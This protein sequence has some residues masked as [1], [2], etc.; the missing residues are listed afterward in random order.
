MNYE[1]VS[2][3]SLAGMIFTLIMCFV[4]A[5]ALM[6]VLYK[7]MK[8]KAGSFF[9]AWLVYLIFVIGL[10]Q[11][12][13]KLI[14]NVGLAEA[15]TSNY[16]I[17][18]LYSGLTAAIFEEG[19][20]F[21]AIRFTMK[22]NLNKYNALMFGLGWAA[23]EGIMVTGLTYMNNL[24]VSL[25]LNNGQIEELLTG[26]TDEEIAATLE[27]ISGLWTMAPYEFFMGGVERIFALIVQVSVTVLIYKA[28]KER[29]ALYFVT[30]FMIHMMIGYLT[31]WLGTS[32]PIFAA[33]LIVLILSLLIGKYALKVYE[34]DI[35]D[36]I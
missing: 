28:V 29:S 1:T 25:M 26:L 17:Y 30:A 15:I 23:I 18:A 4:P 22:N 35:C 34:E 7:K 27:G 13:H 33:D 5:F 16:L 31:V 2:A 6:Y 9:I 21:L 32:L 36:I 14:L 11:L 19:G 12:F 3:A 20:R 10:E 8:I 24:S